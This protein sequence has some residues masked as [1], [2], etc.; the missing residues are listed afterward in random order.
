VNDSAWLGIGWGKQEGVSGGLP[1]TPGVQ[2]A[3]SAVERQQ[4]MQI[5][6][7]E[8]AMRAFLQPMNV[9]PT[10]LDWLHIERHRQA[11]YSAASL[12]ETLA[13]EAHI[14]LHEARITATSKSRS[15]LSR[16]RPEDMIF[17]PDARH[18]DDVLW[19]AERTVEILEDVLENPDYKNATK[20]ADFAV[21][22]EHLDAEVEEE[23]SDGTLRSVEDDLD[24]APGLRVVDVYRIHDRR[25]GKVWSDSDYE[26]PRLIILSPQ[27]ADRVPLNILPW[28][29]RS[30]IYHPLVLNPINDQI[31][32]VAMPRVIEH[33]HRKLVFVNDA[34]VMTVEKM[35]KDRGII[36]AGLLD[37]KE[38]DALLKGNLD[39][40]FPKKAISQEQVITIKPHPVNPELFT[41][42]DSLQAYINRSL[43]SA[44][45][46]QGVEGGAKFATEIEALVA[47]RGRGVKEYQEFTS[48]WLVNTRRT[49][50]WQMHDLATAE[51]LVSAI[52]GIGLDRNVLQPAEVPLDLRITID[53]DSFSA[54]NRELLKKQFREFLQF[55]F[56]E[57]AG[58]FLPMLTPEGMTEILVKALR[59]NGF[60][61]PE[62]FVTTLDAQTQS[63]L[64]QQMMM[65][66]APQQPGP[67]AQQ[68][69]PLQQPTEQFPGQVA[70]DARRV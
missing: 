53:V 28:P 9:Q 47:A 41:V 7:E 42:N 21:R 66:G 59:L 44:E 31:E 58:I 39:W 11:L 22:H 16:V 37:K 15:K 4:M 70:S 17:D 1:T 62:K 64:F 32:G 43:R 12:E 67:N 40:I 52:G 23:Q 35:P 2:E 36:T 61:E 30:N 5:A 50:F 48:T 20:E 6:S 56:V 45:V 29:Y 65:A 51:L 69:P 8:M 19:S 54:F 13:L 34:R 27:Q 60:K 68:A 55:L 38:Q 49:F 33:A 18:W 46:S 24:D 57:S 3:T 14:E 10:D 26:G 25:G 63:M